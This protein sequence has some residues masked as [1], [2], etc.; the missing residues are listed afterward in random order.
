MSPFL[1]ARSTKSFLTSGVGNWPGPA[2]ALNIANTHGDVV[3]RLHRDVT[4]SLHLNTA[5]VTTV[6]AD[7]PR[8][9]AVTPPA[10]FNALNHPPPPQP[11][12][13]SPLSSACAAALA[14]NKRANRRPPF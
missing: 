1:E 12:S 8:W 13:L 2:Y 11:P 7:S 9:A 6:M 10:M 4:K 14:G 5:G 3:A